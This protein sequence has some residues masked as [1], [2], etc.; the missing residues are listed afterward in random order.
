[1]GDI[2]NSGFF[3]LRDLAERGLEQARE[4]FLR[5]LST[6]Q[7]TMAAVDQQALDLRQ[8][9]LSLAARTV[10]SSF[11]PAQTVLHARSP[12][13]SLQLQTQFAESQ[14][15]AMAEQTRELGRSLAEQTRAIGQSAAR[16]ATETV[17]AVGERQ[18][19]IGSASNEARSHAKA[20]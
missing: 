4:A 9:T 2:A 3:G 20:E 15:H 1:M 7:K 18:N 19:T 17:R 13:E 6:A 10:A 16:S 5:F 12:E 14:L 11:E 8:A